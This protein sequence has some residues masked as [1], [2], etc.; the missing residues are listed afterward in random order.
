[1]RN[2][3]AILTILITTTGCGN[4]QEIK[5]PINSY[6]IIFKSEANSLSDIELVLTSNGEFTYYMKILPQPM[7]DEKDEI[8]NCS[9]TWIES[10]GWLKLTFI[11]NPPV[12]EALF[13][14][15]YTDTSTFNIVN[16]KTV[17]IKMDIQNIYIWGVNCVKN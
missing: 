11:E 2:L 7:S 6:P 8:I 15:N 12:L 3:F 14:L 1:M 5:K 13:D 9:G 17:K 4:Q 16:D 10:D